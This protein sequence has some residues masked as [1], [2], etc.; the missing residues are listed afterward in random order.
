MTDKWDLRFL[1]LAEEVATWSKDPSTKVGC[2]VVRPNLTIAGLGFNGFPRGMVDNEELYQD[3]ETKYSRTIHAEVNAILNA[4]E[5]EDC[6]AYIT[7]PPCPHCSLVLIQSGINRVVSKSPSED[8]LGR[9]GPGFQS[10]RGFFAEAEV[11]YVEVD[12]TV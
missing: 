9:W 4:A 6:V 7:A 11:E 10:S 1:R 12:G 3:R 5:T 8:L 2:V